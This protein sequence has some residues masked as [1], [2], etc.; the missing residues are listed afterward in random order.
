MTRKLSVYLDTSVISFLYAED[1]PDLRR[2]TQAFFED[3]V[4][5]ERYLVHISGVVIQEIQKTRD[6]AKRETL[7]EVTRRDPIRILPLVGEA[8]RLAEVYVIEGVVPHSKREDAQHIALATYHQ[9]DALLSWNFKHLAN[10]QKQV[11]VRSI[12]EREGYFYP[13]TLT[14][15]MEVMYE[16]RY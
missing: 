9:M 2:I 7:L 3:Y 5:K 11:L 14:N 1:V 4:R 13:L 16:D 15:P 8:D 6:T 10:I 12:N